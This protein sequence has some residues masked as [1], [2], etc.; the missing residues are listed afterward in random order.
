V[1]HAEYYETILII[2]VCASLSAYRFLEENGCILFKIERIK[3]IIGTFLCVIP[4]IAS[5]F[6]REKMIFGDGIGSRFIADQVL[7]LFILWFVFGPASKGI[8]KR[9]QKR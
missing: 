6:L 2:G 1:N 5:C 9:H 7:D 8:Y 3:L 4:I